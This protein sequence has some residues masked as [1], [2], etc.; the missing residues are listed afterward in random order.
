MLI[1][2]VEIESSLLLLAGIEGGLH[3]KSHRH[4]ACWHWRLPVVASSQRTVSSIVF[5]GARPAESVAPSV[6]ATKHFRFHSEA[7]WGRAP[8]AVR[9]LIVLAASV[10]DQECER[11]RIGMV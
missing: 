3:S 4:K 10:S 6:S 2:F 11:N 7:G 1:R 8:F 5:F 9:C